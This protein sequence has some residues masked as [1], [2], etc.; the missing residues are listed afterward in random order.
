MFFICAWYIYILQIDNGCIFDFCA[1]F[2]YCLGV[3]SFPVTRWSFAGM[4]SSVW[5]RLSRTLS[6]PSWPSE[7]NRGTSH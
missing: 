1:L 6:V 2:F 7:V 5:S 4:V 3:V